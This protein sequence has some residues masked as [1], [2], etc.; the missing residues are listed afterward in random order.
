V[1]SEDE[2]AESG[3]KGAAEQAAEQSEKKKRVGGVKNETAKVPG[4]G[5][6]ARK[7]KHN[8]IE[9]EADGPEEAIATNRVS[10]EGFVYG[11]G[12]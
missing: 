9:D 11:A 7:A 10:C 8:P 4:R 6:P 5:I 1:P 3:C 12:K 2:S